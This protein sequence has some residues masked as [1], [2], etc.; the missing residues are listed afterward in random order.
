M[1][2]AFKAPLYHKTGS[3]NLDRVKF[4][5][6]CLKLTLSMAEFFPSDPF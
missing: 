1:E 4:S 6:H 5:V 2:K 3:S